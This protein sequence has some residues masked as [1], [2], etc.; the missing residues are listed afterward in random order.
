MCYIPSM[1]IS[2]CCVYALG[3]LARLPLPEGLGVKPLVLKK[4]GGG[5]GGCCFLSVFGMFRTMVF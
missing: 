1:I 4:G 3:G 5:G 2:M